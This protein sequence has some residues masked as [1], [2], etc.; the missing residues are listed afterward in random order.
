MPTLIWFVIAGGCLIAELF[1]GTFYLL[2]FGVAFGLAGIVG[3]FNVAF[4]VQLLIVLI[5][6]IGGLAIVRKSRLK[7]KNKVMNDDSDLSLDIGQKITISAWRNEGDAF[8]ATTKYRGASWQVRYQRNEPPIPGTYQIVAVDG[9]VL[10][11]NK[12]N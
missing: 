3:L 9:N 6:S 11:V 4:I 12:V 7:A 8:V 1:S 2:I 5:A 10:V